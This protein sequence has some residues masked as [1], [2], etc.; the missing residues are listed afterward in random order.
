MLVSAHQQL[1]RD[2]NLL[3]HSIALTTRAIAARI[4]AVSDRQITAPTRQRR[5]V[6]R[7]RGAA[8]YLAHV[9]LGQRV[10]ILSPSFHRH[11]SSLRRACALIED[12]RDTKAFDWSL[13]L[14]ETAL[15]A[16]AQS[17]SQG[18]LTQAVHS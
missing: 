9:A 10:Q 4:F 1:R 5:P 18:L 8:I 3:G 13:D 17:F 16:H 15:R 2:K 14:L 7:A 11:P 6:V 12:A